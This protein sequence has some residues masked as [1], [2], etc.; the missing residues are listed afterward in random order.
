MP[1]NYNNQLYSEG[2]AGLID[3]VWLWYNRI[4]IVVAIAIFAVA[5][6]LVILAVLRGPRASNYPLQGSVVNGQ[7]SFV[8]GTNFKRLNR[9][10][11]LQQRW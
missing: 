4:S 7:E 2:A 1:F 11:Q 6:L 3:F 10:R 9:D 8:S 5:I